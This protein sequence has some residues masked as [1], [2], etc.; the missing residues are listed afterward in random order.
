ML[1]DR[2][3]GRESLTRGFPIGGQGSPLAQ[4]K[5]LRLHNCAILGSGHSLRRPSGIKLRGFS[6]PRDLRPGYDF[7]DGVTPMTDDDTTSRLFGD[8]GTNA[9]H[10]Q[11]LRERKAQLVAQLQAAEA[12]EQQRARKLDAKRKILLGAYLLNKVGK[13]PAL[14]DTVRRELDEYLT[15]NDERRLFGFAPLPTPPADPKPTSPVDVSPAGNGVNGRH[16]QPATSPAT[17]SLAGRPM[18]PQDR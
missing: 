2:G 12:R 5:R 4:G 3:V 13:D 18:P 11:K 9:G 6:L 16:P 15:R 7:E 17:V 1:L 14:A 10:V 8:D